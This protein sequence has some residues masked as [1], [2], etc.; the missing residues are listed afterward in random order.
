MMGALIV[1][2]IIIFGVVYMTGIRFLKKIV[3]FVILAAIIIAFLTSQ[4]LFPKF[5]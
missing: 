4:G 5:M 3:G 2:L 1:P